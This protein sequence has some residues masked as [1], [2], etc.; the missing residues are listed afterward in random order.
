MTIAV[1]DYDGAR[2]LLADLL[3][4]IGIEDYAFAIEPAASGWRAQIE[5]A[6]TEGW[7]SSEILLDHEIFAD[8]DTA[9][10]ARS[11]V[12][13]TLEARLSNCRRRR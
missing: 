13:A 6:A 12:L 9:S 11:A 10:E 5:C 3:S 4:E 8:A 1:D 2:R 7:Q